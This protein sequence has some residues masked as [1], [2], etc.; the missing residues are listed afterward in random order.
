M[1]VQAMV[2]A[3]GQ[4]RRMGRDKALL[5]WSGK[6]MLHRV[7]E[8]AAAVTGRRPIVF[9]PWPDRYR[10]HPETAALPVDWWVESSP[11]QG[12]LLALAEL[13]DRTAQEDL[14]VNWLWLLACDLPCLDVAVCRSWFE[15]RSALSPSQ[16]ALV[17]YSD[18]GWEPL[19]G[20]YRPSIAPNLQAFVAKG[21][22]SFQV[23]LDTLSAEQRAIYL[24]LSQPEAA[25]LRNC[26][27]PQDLHDW[28]AKVPR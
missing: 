19:C 7:C 9:S 6:P 12:P 2:L 13:L 23:W 1:V 26:N 27:S 25:T 5:P 11:G 15:R 14:N 3:G 20:F 16:L 28:A 24:P 8:V 22:R 4:S 17:P 18:R 10:I 21:G